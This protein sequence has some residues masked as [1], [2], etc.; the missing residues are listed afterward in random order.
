[1]A[2]SEPL[3]ATTL[4]H[5]PEPRT[6]LAALG[7]AKAIAIFLESPIIM[8]LHTANALAPSPTA[9]VALRRLVG[10]LCSG[11]TLLLCVLLIPPVFEWMTGALMGV[12]PAV[13]ASA[14]WALLLLVLWPAMIGWRRYVQGLL[15]AAGAGGVVG[16][17]GMGRIAVVAG[18]LA[19]GFQV[20][21]WRGAALGAAALVA[22][23]TAEALF[24]TWGAWRRRV[25]AL[26]PP[27]VPEPLP[28]DLA[29]VWRYYRP[30]AGTMLVVWGGR[31]AMIAVIARAGDASVALAAW[32]AAWSLVTVVANATRMVQ[33][34][35]IRHCAQ[36]PV[37][38]LLTFAASVGAVCSFG[39]LLLAT[40]PWGGASLAAFLGQDSALLAAARPTVLLCAL[41]PLLVALQ[42]ALQGLLIAH[43]AT[44]RVQGGAWL[45]VGVGLLLAV[46]GVGYGLPGAATAAGAM[47]AGYALEVMVLGVM[48]RVVRGGG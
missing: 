3:V 41:I 33:Q 17:A 19:L 9:R 26:P 35:T 21:G 14:W 20:G 38:R 44:A 16:R 32:P 42:N 2:G 10:L 6:E 11:L 46:A 37:Q 39:V 15:I 47:A 23:V 30:L 31:A 22:G 7:V 40:T 4:A 27:R 1:M 25:F 34:L 36:V 43:G 18:A 24:V 45:G 48:A 29:G 8:V 5:M 12:S 13:Q 28:Q